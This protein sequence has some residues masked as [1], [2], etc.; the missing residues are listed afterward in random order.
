MARLSFGPQVFV[1]FLAHADHAAKIEAGDLTEQYE[2][3]GVYL[4]VIMERLIILQA[5]FDHNFDIHLGLR[6][7]EDGV[8][9]INVELRALPN[10]DHI[11]EHG[12]IRLDI[13]KPLFANCDTSGVDREPPK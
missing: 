11:K 5:E 2:L 4:R 3:R 13:K 12:V 1:A 7:Y 6:G 10:Q 8:T 9:S